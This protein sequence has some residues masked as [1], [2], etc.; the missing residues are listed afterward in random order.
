MQIR[1]ISLKELETV[2]S[3]VKELYTELSYEVFE[4]R[5]YDMRHMEY[6]MMGIFQRESLVCYAGVAIETSLEY[7]RSLSVYDFVTKREFQK[8]G[9]AHMMLDYLEDYAKMA[10]CEQLLLRSSNSTMES[11]CKKTGFHKKN[12]IFLKNIKYN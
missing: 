1:E 6:K 3:V 8:Q 10:A 7:G 9:Y 2:Y 4:D 11:M 12:Y 5:I